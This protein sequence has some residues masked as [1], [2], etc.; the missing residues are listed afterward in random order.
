MRHRMHQHTFRSHGQWYDIHEIM[1]LNFFNNSFDFH[2]KLNSI[3]N[4]Q[5]M[6]IIWLHPIAIVKVGFKSQLEYQ[7]W[8]Y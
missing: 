7:C 6:E 8:P 3:M 4:D 1:L 2:I 5:I